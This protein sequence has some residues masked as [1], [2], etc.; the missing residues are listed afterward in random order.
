MTGNTVAVT[1]KQPNPQWWTVIGHW[2][3]NEALAIAVIPGR[4]QAYTSVADLE[5]FPDG[6]WE[7]QVEANTIEVAASVASDQVET[8]FA[9]AM[10]N[11]LSQQARRDDEDDSRPGDAGDTYRASTI[12]AS[13]GRSGA[14]AW[15]G[16]DDWGMYD[17]YAG[18]GRTGDTNWSRWGK[19]P[20]V[21]TL[22]RHEF[23]LVPA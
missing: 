22:T 14:G 18:Y 2:I 20:D 10:A 23:D 9:E 17:G 21:V 16:D 5:F 13:A 19:T 11:A 15:N 12:T 4:R 6:L 3:E 7:T 8:D 1:S